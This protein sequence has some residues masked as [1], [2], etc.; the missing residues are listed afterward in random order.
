M[1]SARTSVVALAVLSSLATGCFVIADLDKYS[2]GSSGVEDGVDDPTL[3][4]TLKLTM[5]DMGFHFNQLIEYRVIDSQNAIQSRGF[6]RPLDQPGTI[7]VTLNIPNAIPTGNHPYRFDFYGDMN[8]SGGYDGLGDLLKNDHAWRIDPLVDFPAGKFPH[9]A[10]VVEIIFEHNGVVTD[11]DQ[12]PTSGGMNP[13]RDTGLAA[14]VRFVASGLSGWTGKLLQLRI[15]EQLSG[16]CVALYRVPQIPDTDFDALMPGV[17]DP[18]A[19]YN[20]DIYI[21]ANGDGLYQNPAELTSESD[22]GWRVVLQ[23]IPIEGGAGGGG[24]GGAGGSGGAGGGSGGSGAGGAE[25]QQ[26]LG[27]DYTF[28]SV[29][30]PTQPNVDVGSP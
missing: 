25:P 28:D 12:W 3:P 10:N 8:K 14:R 27:I 4:S 15:T 17:L 16:R 20:L 24:A 29:T 5:I 26:T 23:A 7:R 1:S 21:D 22:L 11:I 19:R 18:G 6:I 30:E 9:K 2:P 13:P